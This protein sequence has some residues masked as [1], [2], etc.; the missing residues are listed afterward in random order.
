MAE[1]A[2]ARFKQS[3]RSP[4][5]SCVPQQAAACKVNVA[6]FCET[7]FS[8]FF[9]RYFIESDTELA[10]YFKKE[11]LK[12]IARCESVKLSFSRAR[13]EGVDVVTGSGEEEG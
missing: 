5:Y 11:P 6:V 7:T 12:G 4:H 2:S 10:S 3:P 1:H 13:Q 9:L 8:T